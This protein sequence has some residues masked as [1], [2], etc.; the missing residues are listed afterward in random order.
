MIV[1]LEAAEPEIVSRQQTRLLVLSYLNLEELAATEG[2]T[3]LDHPD[4]GHPNELRQVLGRTKG[5]PLF[6]EQA[7]KLAM[8]ATEFAASEMNE[9]C[10]AMATFMRR[11]TI[12]RLEHKIVSRMVKRGL[13]LLTE[14][15]HLMRNPRAR[16]TRKPESEVSGH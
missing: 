8:V 13:G 1:S 5:V 10:K 9:L 7:M 14:D 11:G 15:G 16:A 3:W 2:V 6:Q 4:L 12:G